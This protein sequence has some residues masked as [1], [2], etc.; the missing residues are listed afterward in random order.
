[1][2][3]PG[4]KKGQSGNPAGRPRGM[5]RFA[6][7]IMRATANGSELWQIA[8]QIAR[9]QEARDHDRLEAVKFLKESS[10]GKAPLTIEIEGHTTHSLRVIDP[11]SATDAEL[12]VLETLLLRQASVIDVTPA[13]TDDPPALVGSGEGGEGET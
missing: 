5:R 13:E 11:G 1:M 9:N 4:F 3:L 8:L 12:D 7:E 6:K 10:L 2:A